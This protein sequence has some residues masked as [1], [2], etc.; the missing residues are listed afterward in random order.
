MQRLAADGSGLRTTPRPGW[1][2]GIYAFVLPGRPANELIGA[3]L[4]DEREF[5][6]VVRLRATLAAAGSCPPGWLGSWRRLGAG[7]EPNTDRGRDH[8]HRDRGDQPV[9]VDRRA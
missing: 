4:Y 3:F 7:A 9:P 5:A 2:K 6:A 8:E 1:N